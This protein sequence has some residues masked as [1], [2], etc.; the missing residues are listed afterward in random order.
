GQISVSKIEYL[1]NKTL[2]HY[3]Y[4]GNHPYGNGMCVFLEDEK[5]NRLNNPRKTIQ[6]NIDGSYILEC[7]RINKNKGINI[8]TR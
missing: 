3:T 1:K 5:G 4:K 2:V 6:R 7:Y 8:A